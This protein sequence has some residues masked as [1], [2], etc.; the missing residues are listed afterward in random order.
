ME[1]KPKILDKKNKYTKMMDDMCL[2]ITEMFDEWLHEK[3][4]Q[5]KNSETNS[6]DIKSLLNMTDF[7]LKDLKYKKKQICKDDMMNFKLE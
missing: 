7:C 2:S 4:A 3:R 6:D 5:F 1:I